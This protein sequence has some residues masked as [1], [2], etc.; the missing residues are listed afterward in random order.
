MLSKEDTDR[1][2]ST[3]KPDYIFTGDQHNLCHYERD[4][5]IEDVRLICC[6]IKS[7]LLSFSSMWVNTF[8]WLQGQLYPGTLLLHFLEDE[9]PHAKLTVVPCAM[10]NQ[11]HIFLAYL[12]VG[13]A[14]VVLVACLPLK[15]LEPMTVAVS[16]CQRCKV[17]VRTFIFLFVLVFVIISAFNLF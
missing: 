11:L 6:K 16:S 17:R 3:V 13:I 8:S 9:G 1:L 7:N 12:F 5:S 2:L 14:T 10:H 4:G 15:L